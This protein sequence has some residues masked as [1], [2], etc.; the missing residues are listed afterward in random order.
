MQVQVNENKQWQVFKPVTV[1]L[2]FDTEEDFEM[3]FQIVSYNESI[4]AIVAKGYESSTQYDKIY[5]H[6]SEILTK[7]HSTMRDYRIKT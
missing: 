4:P 1:A 7:I 3:F 5:T 2:N 6:C